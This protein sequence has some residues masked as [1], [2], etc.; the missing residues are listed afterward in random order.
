MPVSRRVQ[1]EEAPRTR[2]LSLAGT[3][4][5]PSHGTTWARHG[6]DIA[7]VEKGAWGEMASNRQYQRHLAMYSVVSICVPVALA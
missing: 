6:N 2:F 5:R 4:T 1:Q 3:Y 7:S